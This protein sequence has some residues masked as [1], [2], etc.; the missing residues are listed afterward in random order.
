MQ[1]TDA[2]EQI[3]AGVHRDDWRAFFEVSDQFGPKTEESWS[4][5][6]ER[7]GAGRRTYSAVELASTHAATR[8]RA[9]A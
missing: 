4:P 2:L 6:A 1:D 8:G 7:L 3:M 5:I 9:S